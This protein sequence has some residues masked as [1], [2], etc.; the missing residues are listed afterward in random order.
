V[1]LG[2][3]VFEFIPAI[4]V[5]DGRCVQLAQGDYDRATIFDDDPAAVAA[6]FSAHPI[7]RLHVVD[8]DGAKDCRRRNEK[9][10]R[11]I[12]ECAGSVPVEL[13]G[14]L[15][16]LESI[17]E[18]L[19]T[20]VDRAILGTVALRDPEL[21]RDAARRF[22]G[23]IA[24]GIDAKAGRVA[25][26]GWLDES[27]TGAIEVARRFQ[28][29]G[30]AAIIYTDIESDGMLTGPNLDATAALAREVAVPVIASGGMSSEEDVQRT[31]SYDEGVIAGAIVG[32][33]VYTGAVDIGRVLEKLSCS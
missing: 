12:V 17:E 6:R 3:T 32:T 15:R 29:V 2:V 4:D 5:L 25:V 16:T 30:V 8:L 11:R 27:E 23:R 31:A 7:Q 14:G 26:E 18:V 33:A 13:G 22:P 20:G 21:V 19:A 1:G 10:I 9:T 28:D 24:V